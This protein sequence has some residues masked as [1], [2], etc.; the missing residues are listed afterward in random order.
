VLRRDWGFTGIVM[1]DWGATHDGIAAA[2]GGLDLEMP[3]AEY[4][5]PAT[6]LPAIKAAPSP[7]RPSTKKSAASYASP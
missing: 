6:L 3:S 1:S 2:N 4:M 5:N 7:R